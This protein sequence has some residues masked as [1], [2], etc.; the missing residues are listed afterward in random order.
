MLVHATPVGSNGNP[1]RSI[2]PEAAPFPSD[3]LAYDLVSVP[4]KTRLLQQAAASGAPCLGGLEMLV[5]QGAR[6]FK[7]WTEREA[8]VDVM[9]RTCEAAL[10]KED[11]CAS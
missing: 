11:V 2:W 7:L 6:S 5:S 9:R 10:E 8:P 4:R 3:T 1:E